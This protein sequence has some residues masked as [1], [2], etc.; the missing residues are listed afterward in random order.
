MVVVVVVGGG[1][2][3]LCVCPYMLILWYLGVGGE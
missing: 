3:S 2:Y 1:V